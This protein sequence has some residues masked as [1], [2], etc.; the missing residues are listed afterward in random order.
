MNGVAADGLNEV[1]LDL[2]KRREPRGKSI[3]GTGNSRCKD[4]GSIF[5]ELGE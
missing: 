2:K 5:N 3:L 1:A 4:P